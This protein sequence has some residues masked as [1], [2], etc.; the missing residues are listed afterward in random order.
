MGAALLLAGVG[1]AAGSSKHG[2]PGSSKHRRHPHAT[3]I[4]GAPLMGVN[5]GSVEPLPPSDA[6]IQIQR[7]RALHA[8]VVRTEV[9]WSAL[10]PSGP[11]QI[12]AD[13]LAF[14]DRLMSD[15]A[16][17]G[18]RVIMAVS[19][20]PCWAS[21]APSALVK[22]CTPANPNDATDWPPLQPSDYASFLAYLTR[23]YGTKLAAIEVWNEPD[24]INEQYFAGPEKARRYA[25]VLRASYEAIKHANPQVTVI[26]GSLVGSNGVF[27]RALYANGI[28]GYYDGL[29][30]HFYS[31]TLAA[32]RAIHA[33][34]LANGDQKR[35]WL[36]EFGW[37]SCYPRKLLE[38][39]Q[40]CVTE[41]VQAANLRDTFRALARVPYIAAAV[42]YKLGD[43]TVD[44]FGVL[45]SAGARKPSFG[46]LSSAFTSPFGPIPHV[47]LRLARHGK[48]VVATVSAPVGDYMEL[49]AFV[50]GVFR[51][52]ALF[53]LDRFNRA[54]IALP[55]VLGTR[56][57]R[58]RVWR[59][60]AGVRGATQ[61]RI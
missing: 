44:N 9:P 11:N 49:E 41:S 61:S 6:D 57:I 55:A 32:V 40:A 37:T 23:R 47:R 51:F 42:S 59:E 27:L 34:Q 10:E 56:S 31:L 36:D 54:T 53:V 20:T 24:Q 19:S 4:R 2:R 43:S 5:I 18:I 12:A 17:A 1:V 22:A 46:T 38:D 33:T 13:T 39:E 26:G 25:A 21:S 50:H 52:K 15:A 16:G 45:T 48:H 58:V 3:I 7:A 28:K 29:A 30:I 35:L 60:G 14:M 8:R